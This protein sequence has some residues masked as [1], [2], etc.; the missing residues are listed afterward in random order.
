M[1]QPNVSSL[2]KLSR[3]L[4]RD[5]MKPRPQTDAHF[6]CMGAPPDSVYI[7]MYVLCMYNNFSLELEVTGALLRGPLPRASVVSFCCDPLL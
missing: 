7:R 5:G 6:R 2:D 1:Q 4:L 3:I